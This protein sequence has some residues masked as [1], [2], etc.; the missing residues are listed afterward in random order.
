MSQKTDSSEFAPGFLWQ[1]GLLTIM[2]LGLVL[3]SDK[4]SQSERSSSVQRSPMV[5]FPWALAGGHTLENGM[6][7]FSGKPPEFAAVKDQAA[8]LAGL[9][10][11]TVICPT[12]FFLEWR[13]RRISG[14]PTSER[15][16]LRTSSVF[17]GFC[18]ALTLYVAGAILPHNVR[19][20]QKP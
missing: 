10:I 17:Y 13:R 20:P 4:L 16:P 1:I 6:K 9:L 12:V 5:L 11:G 19:A 2:V 15:P 8:A 7:A 18:G 3:F 14:V